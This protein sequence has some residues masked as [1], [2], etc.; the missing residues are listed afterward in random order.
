MPKTRLTLLAAVAAVAIP[1]LSAC[2]TS[3]GAA[4]IIGT[5]RITTGELQSQVNE[6]VDAGGL[7][8]VTGFDIATFNRELLTHM[9]AV[10]LTETLAREH[11]VVL[12][13]QDITNETNTF[14]QQA[15]G[16]MEALRKQAAQGGISPAQLPAFIRYEALQSKVSAALVQ[17]QPA[18]EAQ[19]KAEYDKTISSFDQTNIAQIEVK[20]N[21]EAQHILRQVRADPSVFPALAKEKSL[22]ESTASQGG[23]V[24]WVSTAQLTSLLGKDAKQVKPGSFV[25]VHGGSNYSVVHVIAH[26][27]EPMSEVTDQLKQSLYGGEAATLLQKAL[28]TEATSA[29]VYASPRYGRWDNTLLAVVAVKSAVSSPG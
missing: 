18:T 9:I 28:R 11:H 5:D 29:G 19:L 22:D 13:A 10:Q 17:A 6:A 16:S 20:T 4:A 14:I 8:T 23:T 2:T 25:V 15:G 27:V 7:T 24:G 1:V 3:P 21:A 12:T 26:R